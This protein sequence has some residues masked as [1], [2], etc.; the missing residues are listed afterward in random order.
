[1]SERVCELCIHWC[2][3]SCLCGLSESGYDADFVRAVH[4]R[5]ETDLDR[6]L[7]CKDWEEL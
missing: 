5:A 6:G 4:Y 3:A 7:W 2:R 1:M